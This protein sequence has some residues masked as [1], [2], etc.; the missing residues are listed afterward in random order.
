MNWSA[1][2]H[3]IR[4]RNQSGTLLLMLPTLWALVLASEGRPPLIL[5]AIFAAG[6]F[7]MRSAGV[8]LNDLADRSIDRQVERTKTRPL[9]SGAL[10]VPVA[11]GIATI[12]VLLAASL[13]M[14]LNRLTLLL[15]PIALLLAAFYPFS[16][17]FLHI[18][19]A[20]LGIAFGWGVVMAWAAVRSALDQPVWLLF[21]ATVFWAIAYDSI[22]ALQDREDDAK[23]G[24]KS[25]AILFGSW[26][27]L[28]VAGSSLATVV[29]LAL[30]GW[31]MDLSPVF[32]GTLSAVAV[33]MGLQSWTLRRG[34]SPARAFAMFKQHRWI[35]G[36]ILAGLWTG[37]L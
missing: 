20:I 17:R 3:L 24:V 23:V 29:C 33:F 12:L 22:Y 35:G 13:L 30:C 9:A 10:G 5:V 26:T 25:S 7:L 31:M 16:K 27:W 21:A 18:P 28:L 19:Q 1:V 32:Y 37:F 2:S 8:V 11:L 34:V 14:F 6:A 15:S 36:A 4:L